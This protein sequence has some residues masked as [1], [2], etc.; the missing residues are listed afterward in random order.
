[1]RAALGRARFRFEAGQSALIGLA[2]SAVR[3]PYSLACSPEESRECGCLEFLI[4][5]EPSGRWG[6][7]F[8]RLARGQ[9]LAVRGPYGSFLLPRRLGR[10][11]LLFIAGGTGIA[12][13]RSMVKHVLRRPRGPVRIVY[14]ARTADDFAYAR[15]L[16]GLAR[17]GLVEVRF[18][19]TRSA[20]PGWRGIRRRITPAD[21]APLVADRAT[22]CFVCGPAAMVAD[23]PVMLMRAGVPRRNI[24]LEQWG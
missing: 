9:R 20:P 12:P 4:R 1:M 5:V 8:D 13:I 16:R 7:A 23:I 14:S 11:P 24:K 22:L 18:H 3:V 10:E 6:H 21:L 2:D 17:R 19:A 15:E